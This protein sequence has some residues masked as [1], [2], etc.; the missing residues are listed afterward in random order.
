MQ[1]V[2]LRP[3]RIASLRVMERVARG[4]HHPE[5][6]VLNESVALDLKELHIGEKHLTLN[7]PR[8]HPMVQPV[9]LSSELRREERRGQR[10]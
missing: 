4:S 1:V 8:G 3:L 10:R 5:E 6:T 7:T 2:H 9:A